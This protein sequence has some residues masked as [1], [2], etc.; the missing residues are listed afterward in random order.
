VSRRWLSTVPVAAGTAT[1]QPGSSVAQVASSPSIVATGAVQQLVQST[2]DLYARA[3][4][5]WYGHFVFN[6]HNYPASSVIKRF[7]LAGGSATTLATTPANYY[8]RHR[9]HSTL[10]LHTPH[11]ARVCYRPPIALAA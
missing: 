2:G 4:G 7:S 9:L 10:K 6:N 5:T 11:E 8:N 1:A 3:G